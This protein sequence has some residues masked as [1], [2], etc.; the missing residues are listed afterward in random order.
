M[1]RTWRDNHKLCKI[2][3]LRILVMHVME[4]SGSQLVPLP[5]EP[6]MRVKAAPVVAIVLNGAP[7]VAELAKRLPV[8]GTRRKDRRRLLSI[9]QWLWVLEQGA[10]DTFTWQICTYKLILN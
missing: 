3:N 9:R 7:R 2:E 8:L 1:G 5:P 10:R 4:R 6:G